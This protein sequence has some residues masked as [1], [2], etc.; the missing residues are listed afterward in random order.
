[1][2]LEGIT[3]EKCQSLWPELV[4]IESKYHS[5]L[6]TDKRYQGYLRRQQADIDAMRKDE[7]VLIPEEIDFAKIGGLSAESQDLLTRYQPETLG[8]ASRIPG[9]TPAALV[10]VLR[11]L[12]AWADESDESD[13]K[14]DKVTSSA[15]SSARS[16][17]TVSS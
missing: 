9:L 3:I 5:Q 11:H 1:M 2:T 13:E 15:T 17:T 8:Q 14:Q 7:N 6:E 16:S 12:R 4:Q 10:A